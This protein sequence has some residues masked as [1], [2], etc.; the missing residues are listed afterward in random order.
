MLPDLAPA[1][2]KNRNLVLEPLRVPDSLRATSRP[3][4]K[5]RVNAPHRCSDTAN[6]WLSAI[7]SRERRIVGSPL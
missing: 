1:D 3:L 2:I 5:N 4:T 7:S 6:I